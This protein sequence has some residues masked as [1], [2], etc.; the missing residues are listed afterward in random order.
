MEQKIL[1]VDDDKFLLDM[2]SLKFSES[3]FTVETA[4]SGAEALNRLAAGFEPTIYLVDIIMPE[5]DG[6]KLIE[7]LKEKGKLP[8]AAAVIL[9]N[10]G[11][12]EDIEKG[13]SLGVDG[14]IVKASATPS[15]VVSKVSVIAQQKKKPQ[16]E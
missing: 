5:V 1:I 11:N 4:L 12:K 6:F 13:L 3:G 7:T 8:R 2:Y 10:L 14:Y 15:E 9:S 16:D